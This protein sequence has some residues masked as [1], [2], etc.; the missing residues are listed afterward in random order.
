[1]VA[2][3]KSIHPLP[4]TVVGIKIISPAGLCLHH[5]IAPLPPYVPQNQTPTPAKHTNDENL[6]PTAAVLQPPPPAPEPDCTPRPTILRPLPCPVAPFPSSAP[7]APH[8]MLLQGC[9][10]CSGCSFSKPPD[11]VGIARSTPS[12][13]VPRPSGPAT[14][15]K[16]TNE[17]VVVQLSTPKTTTQIATRRR[18]RP[19]GSWIARGVSC[20]NCVHQNVALWS[21]RAFCWSAPRT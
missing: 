18:S 10:T 12:R 1:M 14:R 3:S 2:L 4:P 8:Q 13:W 15:A 16:A 21:R 19:C 7:S 17:A 9:F 5:M 20:S 11:I 6:A